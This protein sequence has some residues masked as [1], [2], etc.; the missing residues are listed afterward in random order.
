ML[1]RQNAAGVECTGHDDVEIV[2]KSIEWGWRSRLTVV[3]S[4]TATATT[5]GMLECLMFSL[6]P[7]SPVAVGGSKMLILTCCRVPPRQHHL[8]REQQLRR[9]TK[10]FQSII[11]NDTSSGST[12]DTTK[13]ERDAWLGNSERTVMVPVQVVVVV[14]A[15]PGSVLTATLA[16][17]LFP[18]SEHAHWFSAPLKLNFSTR[19]EVEVVP[20][21]PVRRGVAENVPGAG[22][23]WG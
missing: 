15:V 2:E 3:V 17:A 14:R 18:H 8:P 20:D 13:R 11:N 5:V 19:V 21:R 12:E 6:P 16:A 23:G 4:S 22:C 1:L 9:P 7:P 10:G